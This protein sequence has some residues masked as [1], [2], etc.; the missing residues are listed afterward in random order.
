MNRV[1]KSPTMSLDYFLQF[2]KADFAEFKHV[3]LNASFKEPENIQRDLL[4]AVERAD[5]GDFAQA[6][7]ISDVA[8][9]KTPDNPWVHYCSGIIRWR[10]C[11]SDRAIASLREAIRLNSRNLAYYSCLARML[12]KDGHSHDAL[13]VADQGLVCD[14][15]HI[16]CL[17]E[18]AAALLRLEREAEATATLERVFKLSPNDDRAHSLRVWMEKRSEVVKPSNAM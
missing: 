18:R 15:N 2:Y 3:L 17:C 13:I 4:L 11:D 5:F 9:S 1:N 10:A 7:E 16:G 14:P 8:L 6:I 12:W